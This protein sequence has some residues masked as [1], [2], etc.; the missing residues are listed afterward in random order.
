MKTVRRNSLKGNLKSSWTAYKSWGKG[1]KI[2]LRFT[3]SKDSNIEETYATHFVKT[4]EAAE[5]T[6]NMESDLI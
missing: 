5:K 2:D 3:K 6:H 4:K 1:K